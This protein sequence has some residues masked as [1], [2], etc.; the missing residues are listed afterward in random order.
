MAGFQKNQKGG[1][2]Q[3]RDE[4]SISTQD[5]IAILD[6]EDAQ[7]LVEKAE[8]LAQ[9]RLLSGQPSKQ[10]STSQIR[11]IYGTVKKL[12]MEGQ[13]GQTISKLVL[14]KPKLAYT[15]G[16]HNNI[17][18]LQDLKNVL[19]EAIDLVYEKHDRFMNFCKFFEAILAYHKAY[20]GK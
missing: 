10:V 16:R 11:N 13:T 15:A 5:L 17:P 6:G 4:K 8:D 3:G 19:T 7:K 12:E 20:G 9:N 1:S 2:R 18:G 14:L